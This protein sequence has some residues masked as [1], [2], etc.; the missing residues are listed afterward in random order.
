M[1]GELRG[2]FLRFMRRRR[3]VSADDRVLVAVSGGVD[4]M[5][6]LHLLRDTAPELGIAITA[7]HFDHGMR[8]HSAADA[9]WL[10]GVCAA[11]QLPLI[12]RRAQ[13]ALYGETAARTARYAFLSQAIREA[14]AGRI[15]TAHHADDQ[16]ETVLYRLLRG[17][18]MHGLA[19]IPVRR[20]PI[21]RP[22]LRFRKTE[23]VDYAVAHDIGVREDP[24][25]ET[26]GFMRNRIR[27]A[28]IPV[29]QSVQPQS[30]E[31]VL[32]LAR[33]AAR[34]E[35]AW[36]SLLGDARRRLIVSRGRDV[37]QLALKVLQEY[38]GEIQ[39]RLLRG[40]LRRFGGV[41]DRAATRGMLQF[42]AQAG[43]GSSYVA[44]GGIRLERA[45]EI[46]RITRERAARAEE[47]LAI[48]NCSDGA[49][50]AMI[51]GR[52]W[53]ARW[54]T[55]RE[56][57]GRGERFDCATLRFPLELRG[58]LPGDRIR[59]PYGSKK[60]KKLFAEA[61]VA[62]HQRATVPILVDADGR[63]CWVVGLARSVVAPPA[64][65]APAL[66]IMVTHAERS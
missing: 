64:P 55:S 62:F 3:L 49:G 30:P 20:G 1:H 11:W 51:G 4:S 46:L 15:A 45:Y 37:S 50:A 61:R 14:G 23:L 52:R 29:M 31:A 7:A 24:T 41:P 5:V 10:A 43:S 16:I 54:T 58:W 42:I 9:E 28:L 21:I 22:L 27:R 19:G 47:T 33:H 17:T 6:L 60:L 57:D 26:D 18:G 38:D 65:D 35:R 2:R 25:N 34:T 40:E 48:G 59:L 39:A 36:R 53:Q 12:A 13:Q 44:G 66:T 8:P 63:V 56:S 32:A